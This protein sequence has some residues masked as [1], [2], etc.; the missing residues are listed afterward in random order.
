M[1]QILR[2]LT[3]SI[4]FHKRFEVF[5]M[6]RLIS[7]FL[8]I[9]LFVSFFPLRTF[10]AEECLPIF[11]SEQ[12]Q[13]RTV[14]II[15]YEDGSSL[16][17]ITDSSQLGRSSNTK[18]GTRVYIRNDTSGTAQWKATLTATFTYNGTTSTCTNASCAVTIYNSSW[19]VVSKSTT[20]SGN[21][22]TAHLTM[23]YRV[24]GITAFT[25]SYTISLSCDANGNLS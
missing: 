16:L 14:Q 6:K 25:Q 7:S 1:K 9:L 3:V 5:K 19:Y 18:T 10:A 13:G 11:T 20:R 12:A 2:D 4:M 17:I 22:A 15:Q 24:L 8:V 23:G 21:T